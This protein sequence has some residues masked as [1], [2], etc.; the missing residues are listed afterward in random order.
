LPASLG[1]HFDA[2]RIQNSRSR[3]LLFERRALIVAAAAAA[4]ANCFFLTQ[5]EEIVEETRNPSH[6]LL[7]V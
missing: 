7:R 1:H 4:A 2:H 5:A 3:G 6:G